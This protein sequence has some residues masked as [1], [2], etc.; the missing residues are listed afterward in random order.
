MLR[1]SASDRRPLIP[2]ALILAACLLRLAAFADPP[3]IDNDE[4]RYL[5]AAHHLGTGEVYS[6]WRRPEIH[7]HPLHPWLTSLGGRSIDSLEFR[8]RMV[9]LMGSILLLFPLAALARRLRDGATANLLLLLLAVHPWLVRSAAGVQPESLYVLLTAS[10]ILVLCPSPEGGVA[11]W[12]WAVA[13][14]LFGFSYLARPEGALV[15][16]LTGGVVVVR[17]RRHGVDAAKAAG[18]FVVALVLAASPYLLFLRRQT[19]EWVLTGKISEIFFI[20]QA[21]YAA[22][23]TPPNADALHQ[24]WA[25]SQSPLAFMAAH[26]GKALATVTWNAWRIWGWALPRGLGLTGLLGGSVAAVLFLR[27]R[28]LRS[29]MLLIVCP[30]LTL[31][32]MLFTFPNERVVASVVPFL[33]VPAAVGLSSLADRFDFGTR[34]RRGRAIVALLVLAATGWIGPARRAFGGAAVSGRRAVLQAVSVARREAGDGA[35]I[36]SDNPSLSF[37]VAD[38][39]LFG[40]PGRYRPLPIEPTCGEMA[41]VLSE[42]G[43]RVALLDRPLDRQQLRLEGG[44]CR[45]RVVERLK[46]PAEGR[47]IW[48]VAT[49]DGVPPQ[50]R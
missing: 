13:G 29:R 25:D 10:A 30:A 36:A 1:P 8:G 24:V 26:P 41:N 33:L 40:P 12:R 22:K 11:T 50:G 46:L 28:D 38:P 48:I 32:L 39:M 23:G 17:S 6:D 44:N 31:F 37:Y 34:G 5:I 3:P 19:G 14:L 49:T 4:V 20:G 16:L 45:L 2:A 27:R 35:A 43:A 9:N 47:A 18:L 7:I 21:L 15:G 42:R